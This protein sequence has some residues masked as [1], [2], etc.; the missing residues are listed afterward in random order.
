MSR[1]GEDPD[2]REQARLQ[3]LRRYGILDTARDVAFD[4]ITALASLLLDTPIALVTLV[5]EHRQWFKSAHGLVAESTPREGGFCA[6]TVSCEIPAVIPDAREDPRFAAHPMVVG[7]PRIRL[8][9]G[10]PL[11]TGDGFALGTLCVIDDRPR[12]LDARQVEILTSLAAVVMDQIETVSWARRLAEEEALRIKGEYELSASRAASAEL[13]QVVEMT[14]SLERAKTSFFNLASHE[15][16]TPLTII[17][18]YLELLDEPAFASRSDL[19]ADARRL[20]RTKVAEM[21]VLISRMLRTAE[22]SATPVAGEDVD[23]FE[24]LKSVLA[25]ARELAPGKSFLLIQ[26]DRGVTVRGDRLRLAL[27]FESLIDNAI[28]YSPATSMVTCRVSV[29]NGTAQVEIV[30]QGTDVLDD[31]LGGASLGLGVHLVRE[32]IG[33]HGGTFELKPS[34]DGGSAAVV[35]LPAHRYRSARREVHSSGPGPL[36]KREMEIAR[37]VAQGLTNQAI[38]SRLFLSS[39]TIATHIGHI[40]AKR[41]FR[42]RAQ[43]GTWIAEVD[44]EKSSDLRIFRSPE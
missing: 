13:R 33:A 34:L 10:A 14:A 31:D 15:L 41:G 12:T 26:S 11:V 7:D 9:A 28:H 19:S 27:A 39:A 1:P 29:A 40:L 44:R 43:V 32:V 21:N 42:S 24:L 6:Y 18:G 20:M 30:D 38:A 17:G 25:E 8:Y 2:S 37:L 3:A 23:I 35:S 16:R 4:R 22:L 36:S 5:D